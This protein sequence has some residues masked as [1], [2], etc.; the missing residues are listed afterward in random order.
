MAPRPTEWD[1]LA[2]DGA[3]ARCV[4]ESIGEIHG[5]VAL[6]AGRDRDGAEGAVR[7][8]YA[9][10]AAEVA[11]GSVRS[12]TLA[13]L[14][15]AARRLWL[16]R[17]T[18]VVAAE[19]HWAVDGPRVDTLAGLT[20]AE[21][22]V[23][24]LRLVN[25]MPAESVADALGLPEARV[26]ELE[27]RATRR[28]GGDV[29]GGL[30]PWFGDVR[31]RDELVDEVAAHVD[32]T[33]RAGDPDGLDA[34]RAVPV[35][36]PTPGGTAAGGSAPDADDVDEPD[37]EADAAADDAADATAAGT[38]PGPG[39][40]DVRE[41]GTPSRDRAEAAAGSVTAELDAVL[42]G[43]DGVPAAVPA[44]EATGPDPGGGHDE[45]SPTEAHPASPGPVVASAVDGDVASDPPVDD[46]TRGRR[47][48]LPVLV[49]A[50]L[51]VLAGAVWV[52]TR[53]GDDTAEDAGDAP[54]ATS[55]ASTTTVP[56]EGFV[57]ACVDRVGTTGGAGA[58]VGATFG[59]VGPAPALTISLPE[60]G[61]PDATEPV[62]VDASLVDGG[63]LVAGRSPEGADVARTMIAHV[64]LDGGVRWVRCV[65]EAAQVRAVAADAAVIGRGGQWWQ[66][67]L[68]DGSVGQAAPP[69][70]A[71]TPPW[72]EAAT[73]PDDTLATYEWAGFRTA[74]TG[75][76]VLALG[77]AADG[78][79]PS[80]SPVTA[81]STA[82]G[83][84]APA[85]TAPAVTVPAV[86]DP[87]ACERPV[88]RGYSTVA[89]A[90]PTTAPAAP[91]TSAPATS[92]PG[93]VVTAP[94]LPPT[95]L[96]RPQLLWEQAGATDV[97]AVRDG[98]A[99]VRVAVGEGPGSWYL[100]D[101]RTGVAV[102]GQAWGPDR[103]PP[104]CCGG[105]AS[106]AS[107]GGA[108]LVRDGAELAV[109]LPEGAAAPAAV[110]LP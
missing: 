21:R 41:A 84:T 17:V 108:L 96:E 9:A 11:T 61:V 77:C 46:D 28:L 44:P 93:V 39:A 34:T 18:P 37:D 101:A 49:V 31:P 23:V 102:D 95:L 72:T 79:P 51:M 80:T 12:I 42:S 85:T 53:G 73:W 92:A 86:A 8:L 70:P 6:L 83:A 71:P 104:S 13:R 99:L 14:R 26:G 35:I 24:V 48:V 7:E 107:E 19:P 88:L 29:A 106:V 62:A 43:W 10:L 65:D 89:V 74:T 27:R 67:S 38:A 3:L 45:A 109:W 103:F 16:H 66:L 33:V 47:W 69:P 57:P 32:A 30:R 4:R 56:G 60:W 78:P 63:V 105:M 5:Y 2:A 75:E 100:V 25:R 98:F 20:A 40:L 55:P 110:S 64:G 52:A 58:P 87:D 50:A 22:T 15:T 68:T 94:P 1:H 54:V 97:I 81:P 90:P 82:P 36:E 76:L 59:P 91:A